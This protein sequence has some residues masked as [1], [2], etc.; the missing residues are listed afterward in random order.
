MKTPENTIQAA[1][2]DYLRYD[3]RI[4][5]AE[6]FNT[7]AHVVAE[8]GKPRRFIKFAFKGCSDILGQ[9]QDGRFL[10][11]EVKT[12]T[13]RATKEQNDFLHTVNANHGIGIL[14]RSVDDVQQALR[15][16]FQ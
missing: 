4:A 2:L 8:K 7:G 9:T 15:Q 3:Q 11:I 12:K 13:G 5:W 14:A 10:A 6:R 16:A 1:I